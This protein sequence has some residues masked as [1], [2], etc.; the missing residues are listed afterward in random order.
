[1]KKVLHSVRVAPANWMED[2]RFEDLIKLLDKYP[3]CF[4][5]VALFT[6]FVHSPLKVEEMARRVEIMKKRLP[7]IRA[8]GF[9]AGI[10]ILATIGHHEED[11]DNSF[12]GEYHLM[13]NDKGAGCRGSFCMNDERFLRDHVIPVYTILAKAE[14]EFIWIDDDVRYSHLP[15]G[16][17]C[18]CDG[19]IEKFNRENNTNYTREE[20]VSALNEEN[21]AL[22][23][24]W[25]KHNG[26]AITNLFRTIADTVYSIDENIT[27]G[28]MTGERYM[29]G[30]DFPAFADALSCGGKK[31]IMWRPGGGAYTD[32]CY[33]EIVLKS[34]ETGRQTA[35]LPKYVESVQYELEAFPYQLI[36]KSPTS[37]LLETL[38]VMTCGCTGTAYNNLPGETG[39]SLISIE[40]HVKAVSDALPFF[41]LLAEKVGGRQPVGI[42][43]GWHPKAQITMPKGRF[44]SKGVGGFQGYANELFDFG[45]PEA[46]A[47]GRSCVTLSTCNGLLPFT[48]EEI[49]K[50]LKGGA[51]LDAKALEYVNSRGFGE[52][53]GFAVDKE[54]PVD[55][56]EEYT[57]HTLNEGIVGKL[58]N[59]RQAFYFGD[60]FG[61]KR[62]DDGG[63]VLARLCDYHNENKA[64]ISLGIYENSL[65]GRVAAA[66]YYPFS[67]VSDAPKSTQMKRVMRYLSRD[68]LPSYV[69]SLVRIRNHTFI[70][71]GRVYVALCNPTN[72]CHKDVSVAIRTEAERAVCYTQKM[73]RSELCA[74]ERDGAYRSFKLERIE[75]YS[76][77]LIEI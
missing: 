46:F 7:V 45:L 18:F 41:R 30:Y 71:D 23:L 56:I 74:T 75:P 32:Y 36:K 14:P 22:R 2:D 34:S 6:S 26:D 13:T 73:E 70:E 47:I 4:D 19:C 42:H 39:E 40:E 12:S 48:D 35:F 28:F 44:T 17:C 25:L 27:L 76:M 29:E 43:S 37:T 49:E 57:H 16:A 3:E 65:G 54:I 21:T 62:T 9:S 61:L 68:T 10:N 24:S 50:I 31:K 55:A 51:Y 77:V 69:E 63:E 66:G 8:H 72:E 60:S 67:W 1:M 52:L 20:L 64:D 11:L 53:T 38:W 59:S 33:D 58:R 15:V 5:Q